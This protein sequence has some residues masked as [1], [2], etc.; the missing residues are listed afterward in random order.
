MTEPQIYDIERGANDCRT[1][2][3]VMLANGDPLVTYLDGM[4]ARLLPHLRQHTDA[5]GAIE[6]GRAL[7]A[8]SASVGVLAKDNDLAVSIVNLLAFVGVDLLDGER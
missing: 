1:V 7:I 8:A 5:A 3:R 2:R 6:W 4:A